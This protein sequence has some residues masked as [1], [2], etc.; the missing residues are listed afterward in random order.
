LNVETKK[1]FAMH[2]S[3]SAVN[4]LHIEDNA[5]MAQLVI[6]ALTH[7]SVGNHDVHQV[8]THAEG[9]S[10]AEHHPVDVVLLDL[11]LPDSRGVQGVQPLRAALP[12]TPIIVV[13]AD[14]ALAIRKQCLA[15]GADAFLSK[16]DLQGT[17][18]EACVQAA[19]SARKRVMADRQSKAAESSK[20]Y[21]NTTLLVARALHLHHPSTIEHEWRVAD[22]AD[23]IARHMGLDEA[24][25]EAVHAAGIMHDVGKIALSI[26]DV[27][28][29]E[30]PLSD[31]DWAAI[32]EHPQASYDVI[33]SIVWPWPVADIVFQHHER[34][35]GSGYPAGLVGE[36]IL[37]EARILAVA[38]AFDARSHRRDRT[39]DS[40]PDA[41][42]AHLREGAGTLYDP[43][44]VDA[45]QAIVGN[46]GRPC[47]NTKG[48]VRALDGP[49]AP[50]PSLLVI[51]DEPVMG[52]SIKRALMGLKGI[53][54]LAAQDG[55]SGLDL[56]HRAVP[57]LILL[58][59]RMPGMSGIEVLQSLKSDP[60]TASIPVM[61]LSAMDDD[62]TRR[63]ADHLRV[64]EYLHKPMNPN[65][66]ADIVASRLHGARA[67]KSPF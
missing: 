31:R 12:H 59:I 4:V 47:K 44:V 49:A 27:L 26:E 29:H 54:V 16:V 37:P 28:D 46:H 50:R 40:G 53:D 42:L 34:M 35:D 17:S 38:D 32:R 11:G 1:G 52:Q 63:A 14:D 2:H 30:G 62:Q 6:R 58:D 22:M 36:A 15:L 61:I 24:R 55:M 18:L 57:S 33:S 45:C 41:A 7:E 20:Y 3:Q 23:A 51:D 13:S 48:T 67:A 43:V 64:D 66:L 39:S 19:Y 56:A 65:R 10:H 60:R 21:R 25:V 9:L 5:S 8:K